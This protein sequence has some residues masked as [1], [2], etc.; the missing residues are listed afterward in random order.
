MG[1]RGAGLG[2]TFGRNA[3]TDPVAVSASLLMKRGTVMGLEDKI[4]NAA[5]D[6]KG[7]VKEATGR[8]PAMTACRRR[9]RVIRRPQT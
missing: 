7:K 9:V 8:P 4:S 2:R 3:R 5:E 6:A 1:L